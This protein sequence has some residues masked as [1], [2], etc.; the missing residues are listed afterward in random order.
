MNTIQTQNMSSQ[1]FEN[2]I[3]KRLS[4]VKEKDSTA[5]TYKGVALKC[6]FFIMTIIA[7]AALALLLHSLPLQ[8]FISDDGILLTYAEAVTA[9]IAL[10]IFIISPFVAVFAKRTIPVSGA[11]YCA[12]VGYVYTF[13]GNLLTEFRSQIFLA[14]IITVALFI[15]IMLVHISGKINVNKKFFAVIKV[16]FAT[17]VVSSLLLTVA[18]FIPGL[19]QASVFVLSNPLISIGFSVIGIA[20]ASMFLLADLKTVKDVVENKLP[21]KYEWAGAF[22]IIFS[23]IWLFIQVLNLI[24][25]VQN[26]SK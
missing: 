4:K 19:N 11:L 22:G 13:L 6:G 8:S 9:A 7:G 21:K 17:L 14:L 2:P 16:V 25:K 3:M 12:G 18:Y 23:V 5:V 1:I 20:T 15:A 10:G 26:S 24:S